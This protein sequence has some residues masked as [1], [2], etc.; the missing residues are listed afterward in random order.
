M[1]TPFL[2][3]LNT[4]LYIAGTTTIYVNLSRILP[5]PL[6]LYS[7]ILINLSSAAILLISSILL[8][9]LIGLI[10]YQTFTISKKDKIIESEQKQK[11]FFKERKDYY[12][13]RFQRGEKYK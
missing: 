12:K 9:L 10:L 2:L 7:W 3:R 8:L 11:D 6:N 13:G 4:I 1:N 5:K